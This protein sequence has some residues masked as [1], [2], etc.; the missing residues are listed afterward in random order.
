MR[1]RVGFVLCCLVM[2][3]TLLVTAPAR[4]IPFNMRILTADPLT[5]MSEEIANVNEVELGCDDVIP[6]ETA[7]CDGSNLPYGDD[8]EALQITFGGPNPE[9]IFTIDNDPVITGT[10]TVTN[11]QAFTQHF[12]LIF[13]LPVAAMP[14]SV[15][16]GSYRAT[17][18]DGGLDGNGSTLATQD[19]GN[20]L[21]PGHGW[22]YLALIDGAPYG[23]NLY[24]HPQSFSS[25][26]AAT[27]S[28][29]TMTF[30]I[31]VAVDGPAVNTSIGIRLD[32]TLTGN[33]RASFTSNH[34]VNVPE[35]HTGALLA[36]GLAL[37]ARRRRT[38]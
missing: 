24:P 25:S 29:P 17:V 36:L 4:A 35:P 22:L 19:P 5:G 34:I 14:D 31:P 33:D 3:F 8:Y 12:S 38:G 28:I 9:D 18:R 20:I 15:T 21:D 13:T 2:G 26:G 23:Q 6:G 7:T 30:G 37:F 11:S 27:T 10:V 1:T 16:S 32:F